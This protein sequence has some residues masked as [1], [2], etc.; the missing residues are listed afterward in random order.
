M[1]DHIAKYGD[2]NA[3]ILNKCKNLF[4][5][6]VS[7]LVNERDLDTIPNITKYLYKLGIKSFIDGEYDNAS[8]CSY[9]IGLLSNNVITENMWKFFMDLYNSNTDPKYMD[10]NRS[11]R[12]LFKTVSPII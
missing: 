12:T 6:N 1:C 8:L 7:S 10:F 11:V 3:D 2:S 5:V 4:N 9:Y